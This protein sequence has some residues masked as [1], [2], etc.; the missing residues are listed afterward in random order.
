MVAV[1]RPG[2]WEEPGTIGKLPVVGTALN[3]LYNLF[4]QSLTIKSIGI[5]LANS[6][7]C[8][9]ALIGKRVSILEDVSARS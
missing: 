3:V 4:C 7:I 8:D 5:F 6:L 1:D 9:E 2:L